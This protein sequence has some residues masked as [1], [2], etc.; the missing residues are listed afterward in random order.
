M[1]TIVLLGG[2]GAAGRELA[3]LL[4]RE[5]EA[6]LVLVGRSQDKAEAL[7]GALDREHPGRV[8]AAQCDATA[9]ESLAGALRGAALLVDLS[10]GGDHVGGL[11]RAALKAGADFL[12]IHFQQGVLEQLLPLAEDFD[13]AGRL[14]LTLAGSHPGLPAALVR[15][16]T[17]HFDECHSAL[18]GMGLSIRVENETT[19]LELVDGLMTARGALYEDGAW[20]EARNS[21]VRNLDL[22]PRFGVQ[23]CY[24]MRMAELEALPRQFGLRRAGV[25]VAGFNP[26]VDWALL[27]LII[28][29]GR[30]GL[31]GMRPLLARLFTWGVNAFARDA[32]GMSLCLEASGVRQGR[33]LRL[34]LQLDHPSPYA[35]TAIP[36]AACLRQWQ[37]GSLAAR[38]LRF[39][40][41]AVDPLR[42]LED[43]ARLGVS[44]GWERAEG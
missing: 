9:P 3:P 1:K 11:A 27:P 26:V 44:V 33:P 41:Q 21:D 19:A 43:M 42:L 8:R 7:A 5:T 20:R 22:G 4:L 38:G 37:D 16:A 24:P 40:G 13:S 23:P 15:A 35:L 31:R 17:P 2:Y 30:V 12:D 25:Y 14:L 10:P 29:C 18:V 39:M 32:P 28:L 34:R 6:R 36:V